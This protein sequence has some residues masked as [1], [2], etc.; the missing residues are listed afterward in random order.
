MR[1]IPEQNAGT[2]TFVGA[3]GNAVTILRHLA[4]AGRAEGVAQIARATGTNTSTCFNILRT[5]HTEGLVDFSEQEKLYS[6]SIGILEFAL[7]VMAT[8]APD[9]IRPV[10]SRVSREED[11][12]IALWKITAHERLILIDR[13][14]ENRIVHIDMRLGT[15]LP[16]FVGALG[17][18]VAAERNL[19]DAELERRFMELRWSNS[20]EFETYRAQVAQARIDGYAMDHS[21]LYNLIDIVAAV[22][23]DAS[24]HPRFGI[25]AIGISGQKTPEQMHQIGCSLKAAAERISLNLFGRRPKAD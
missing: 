15:R 24:G 20:P 21:N 6:L 5:L 19:D 23:Q 12:L 22:I 11:S 17:R 7:P 18:C 1:K 10:L 4:H 14:V 8:N 25:S 2:G 13:I 16:S 3:V 9:L